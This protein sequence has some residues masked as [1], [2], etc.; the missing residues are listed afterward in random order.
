MRRK[1]KNV[2]KEWFVYGIES[3]DAIK[4][5]Y[6]NNP[7]K[8]L[9]SLQTAN[10]HLLE[11]KFSIKARTKSQAKFVENYLHDRLRHYRLNGEW[12]EL[13]VTEYIVFRILKEDPQIC[14]IRG[15]LF[16]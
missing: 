11:L 15:L 10:P 5:G 16:S 14:G 1:K 12:F 4:I 2:K 7:Q 13:G 9:E 8:R 6:S 3:R